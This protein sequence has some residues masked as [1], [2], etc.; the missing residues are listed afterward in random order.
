MDGISMDVAGRQQHG[1]FVG[2]MG[3]PWIYKYRVKGIRAAVRFSM[4][5]QR[6]GRSSAT[7]RFLGKC[8]KERQP[9]KL[10]YI[11]ICT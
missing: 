6:A 11:E 3:A 5:G 9:I 7:A 1:P 2:W 10:D 8:L 4:L